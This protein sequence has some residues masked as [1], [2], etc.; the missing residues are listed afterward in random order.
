MLASY[1]SLMGEDGAMRYVLSAMVLVIGFAAPAWAEGKYD[2][3]WKGLFVAR[4]GL[5]R[6]CQFNEKYFD[7]TITDN[8]FS[9]NIN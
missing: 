1:A 9:A 2:G 7:V 8:E 6:T 4:S 3:E 5:S